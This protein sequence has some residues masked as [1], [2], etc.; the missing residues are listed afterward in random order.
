LQSKSTLNP[1]TATMAFT[2]TGTTTAVMSSTGLNSLTFNP[3]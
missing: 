1:V 2:G 3:G